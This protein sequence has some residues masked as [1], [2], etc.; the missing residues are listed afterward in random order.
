[1]GRYSYQR[2]QY[3]EV[4][5]PER[6]VCLMANADAEW[7]VAPNPMMPDWPRIFLTVVTFEE[8]GGRTL[9]R[10]TWTPH[11]ATAAEVACFAGAMDGMGKGWSAGM[12]VLEELLAE[13][14]PPA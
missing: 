1:L 2:T 14:Q 9:M 8:Q 13:L 4:V 10:L 11:E 5:V 7:N 3:T 6:L 12:K